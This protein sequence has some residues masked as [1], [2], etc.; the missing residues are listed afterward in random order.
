MKEMNC[1]VIILLVELHM[2]AAI[3]GQE[4]PAAAE[5]QLENIAAA[6]DAETE[7][8]SY[9]QEL[10]QFRKNPLDLNTA[11]EAELKVLRIISDLQIQQFVSYRNLF[12]KLISIYE[13]QAIPAW[14]LVTIKKLVPFISI[15]SVINAREDFGRR[16]RNG[17]H[18]LLIRLSQVLEPSKGFVGSG[19]SRYLGSPQKMFFR[20]RYKYK[21]LLQWGL[22]ADKDAGEQFFRGAQKSGFDFYSMHLFMGKAGIVH[23]LALG[24]YTVN[25]GQGL[26]QWQSLAFK[27]GS[28]T[29]AI[30]R[31][32]AVLHPYNSAG[33][34]NFYRGAAITIRKKHFEATTFVSFRKLNAN[35]I[36]DSIANRKFVTSLLSSGY[37]RTASEIADRKSLQ[38]FSF[39][40]NITYSSNHL[41]LGINSIFHHFSIPIRKSPE[42]YNKYSIVGDRWNNISLD[43]SYTFRNLHFFGETAVDKNFH[44]AY[45]NG[46]LISA[47]QRVDLSLLYRNIEKE[48]Q[49]LNGNAFTENSVPTNERGMYGGISIRPR[50]D[51]QIDAYADIYSFP[52]IKFRVD[53]PSDG[54]DY[55]AQLTWQPNKRVEIYT[56]YRS[57]IKQAN[58]VDDLG[59]QHPLHPTNYIIQ[60]PREDWRI[61]FTYKLSTSVTLR[62]REELLHYDRGGDSEE[63]GFLAFFDIL[64]RP[65]MRPYSG[66]LRLQYMETGG[67]NSRIYAYENDVLYSYSIPAFYDKGYHYYV[68]A[69]YDF[70][71]RF[72]VWLH[73][74]QTLYNSKR[75]I[76]SGLDEIDSNHRSELKMEGRFIL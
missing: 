17:E 42:P 15:S 50:A 57:E 27:K 9:Q 48:Y 36:E 14:D 3:Y 56:R 18:S 52:G 43:Y 63:R 22:T 38:Q 13:L 26:I 32:S 8:D 68:N 29:M 59:G 76:G 6:A 10:E 44:K 2:T 21:N 46:L 64:Y 62:N 47:D 69:N 73:W 30:K 33:E 19:E 74:S 23:A 4:I 51:W 40:G 28:G 60:L 39:G 34:F 67:Y 20:Y 49:A 5:Q 66:G 53:A 35:V 31:Q 55:C 71:K 75:S 72:S 16:I 7:D 41:H 61:Q 12:G 45:L 11:D 58:Q 54:R 37:N 65:L 24:D 1:V 25:V 70:S